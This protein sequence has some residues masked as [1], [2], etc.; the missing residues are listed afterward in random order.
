M[1]L[2]AVAGLQTARRLTTN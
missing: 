1:L 2:A